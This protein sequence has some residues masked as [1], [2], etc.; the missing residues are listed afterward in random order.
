V[1]NVVPEKGY[2]LG[3][4]MVLHPDVRRAPSLRVL[5]WGVLL[6]IGLVMAS[7][8][9]YHARLFPWQE[10]MDQDIQ[11]AITRAGSVTAYSQSVQTALQYPGRTLVIEGTYRVDRTSQRYETVSTTTLKRDDRAADQSF[12]LQ[13]VSIGRDVYVKIDTDSPALAKTIPAS[14][15][16]RHFDALGIPPQFEGI[17]TAGP[18]L[19][20]LRIFS[21]KGAYLDFQHKVGPET[22]GE[23]SLVRYTFRLSSRRPADPDDSLVSIMDEIADGTVEVWIDPDHMVRMLSFRSPGYSSTT[24]LSAIDIPQDIGP[25]AGVR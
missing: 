24:T 23:L 1:D 6:A 21:E 9:A 3:I 4:N 5:G 11:A 7:L 19:D 16:W 17:A 2:T 20:N 22:I 8:L 15:Q 13:D 25:P 10:R 14:P 18:I 12:T